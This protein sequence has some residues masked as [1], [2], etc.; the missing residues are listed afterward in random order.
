MELQ[1]PSYCVMVVIFGH[2]SLP[3]LSRDVLQASEARYVSKL[4]RTL[5]IETIDMGIVLTWTLKVCKIE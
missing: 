2:W 3:H 5:D 1:N 4:E